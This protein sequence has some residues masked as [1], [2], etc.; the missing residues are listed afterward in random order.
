[1]WTY[2]CSSKLMYTC[3]LVFQAYMYNIVYTLQHVRPPKPCLYLWQRAKFWPSLPR[4]RAPTDERGTAELT[5]ATTNFVK[6]YERETH[7]TL[8][9][10]RTDKAKC[11][12]Y[13]CC[14]IN[15]TGSP[16]KLL[17]FPSQL[18]GISWTA[19]VIWCAVW[20]DLKPQLGAL[21]K[22]GNNGFARQR[23][24]CG[25][26]PLC[27]LKILATSAVFMCAVFQHMEMLWVFP[28]IFEISI[29]HI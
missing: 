27:K 22:Q 11:S 3:V 7:C 21:Y 18:H 14:V 26:T 20:S 28:F 16:K 12:D 9:S 23:G 24:M 5:D 15:W 10:K 4:I 17:D 25:Q 29:S 19:R 2:T 1:M 8:V 6:I 13:A